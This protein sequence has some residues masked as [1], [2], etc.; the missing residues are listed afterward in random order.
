MKSDDENAWGIYATPIIV[1]LWFI[2]YKLEKLNK[3]E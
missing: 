2:Q 1:N 3:Y